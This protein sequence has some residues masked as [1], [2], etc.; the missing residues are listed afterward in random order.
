M[1]VAI[2][3]AGLAGLS[4]A[5]YLV[6]AGHTPIVLERRN[7]LGGKVAA[8][9]DKDGDWYETGLH[10]FFGAYPNMLQM[11]KELGIEDRLQWKKHS[12]IFNQPDAPGTY[13]RFDFPDLPAP[14]NGLV[15]ILR[16]NDMLTWEEKIKFGIGLM[17]AIVQ[18]QKYVEAMDKYS[19]SEWMK[20]QNIPE[21]VEKEVFI[22]MSKALNFINPDEIS[23]TILLTALNRFLQEKNGSKMAFL[24]GPPTTRLCQPMV[25]YITERGGEVHLKRPLKEF[26]LN[27]DGTVKG[28]LLRGLDGEPDE[29]FTADAYVSAMPV[30][31]LKTMLPEPWKK[32]E[33]FNKLNGLEGVPVINLHMW[34]D[35]KLTDVDHLLFSR[36]PLL[37][38]YADMSNTCR[39][40][41]SD[42]SMLE[43]VLAPAKDWISKS[44][45]EI[46]A[47]TM[48]ELRQ[49]FPDDFS[50]E[51]QAQLLK[52]HVVKTPRSV[53]KSTPGRQ[54]CRPSQDT[55]VK[56]FFL[57]GDYTMQRYLASMEGAV[58]SGKLTAQAVA[59]ASENILTTDSAA[60]SVAV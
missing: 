10:I 53:Y 43:L 38:V 14:V 47:V 48:E 6:D 58:L 41:Y 5:K 33:F 18:G 3:G 54:D 21:R 15:A 24:D 39:E 37:S 32:L 44:D 59:K 19:W 29:L 16:N 42:N 7:V 35:R 50:G 4:C 1:R 25:D 2:A 45:E 23:A 51:D 57:T 12:M 20:K 26:V 9:Q 8:W 22:A 34:F 11:F 28:Y 31:P 56:N 40:Y 30:D 17:P 55:P 46:I 13:S 27:D 60:V 36:S 52:Y 49:L